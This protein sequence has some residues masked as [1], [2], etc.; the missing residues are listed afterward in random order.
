MTWWQQLI[1]ALAGAALIG[2]GFAVGFVLR[3]RM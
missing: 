2:G 3:G 1:D